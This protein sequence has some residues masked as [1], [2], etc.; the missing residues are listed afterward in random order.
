MKAS[1]FIAKYESY[2]PQNLSMEG[3]ISGL[4][5]GSL[6][7]TIKRVM[8]TLDVRETTVT[9]AIARNVDMI[10]TKHAPIFRPLK[11]LVSSPRTDILLELVKHDISVYVSH[12]NIDV[13]PDGL[14]DWFCDLLEIEDTEV[15][16]PT[17]D[18]YGIGRVGNIRPL[19]LEELAL[20]VKSTFNLDSVRLVRYAGS[21]PEISRVAICGGSGQGFYRDALTRDAQ[22]LIT[23]D[24]YYH[25]AQDMITDGLL[26]ID[27]GHHIEALFIERLVEK[28][29]V[30]IAE[31]DWDIEVIPSQMSTN[32][33]SHL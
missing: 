24:I 2:C 11:D 16:T 25:T 29:T 30:W 33:F 18:G 13:V 19:S 17:V 20:K 1:D 32:P 8:V 27:P 10:V 4:Q 6:D 9:E 31:E 5:L 14:N 28:M 3:D 21:N 22:V 26:A 12:T 7:K 23:G 15:L